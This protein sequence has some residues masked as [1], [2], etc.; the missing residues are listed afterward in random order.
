MPAGR[1]T[2]Y[3]EETLRIAKDYLEN[4]SSEEY[5]DVIPQIS[6][7]AVALGIRRETIYDWCKHPDKE[8]F[9]N[10][11]RMIDEK[12]HK[13][14]VNGSLSGDLN[15]TISKL[16]LS[17]NHGHSEKQ[18]VDQT[19]KA[20]HSHTVQYGDPVLDALRSKHDS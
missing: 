3:S 5:G 14:L 18:E 12:Q 15:P 9:S 8:D 2:K 20:E 17:S 7:L 11:V 19:V 6:G 10:T 13:T 4:Y 1:P 16:L